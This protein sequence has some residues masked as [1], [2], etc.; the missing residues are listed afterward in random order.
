[1]PEI[2]ERE[3]NGGS[4]DAGS[5][6]VVLLKGGALCPGVG[7]AGFW[8]GE[9]AGGEVT[10]SGVLTPPV[11]PRPGVAPDEMLPFTLV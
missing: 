10:S 1:V 11:W 6:F 4:V 7:Q 8:S 3:A 5:S 9:T 2:A